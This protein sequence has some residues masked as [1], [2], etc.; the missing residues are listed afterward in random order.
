MSISIDTTTR[1]EVYR[2][3]VRRRWRWRLLSTANG[4]ILA[5]SGQGYSRR[6]DAIAGLA[7]ATG[8][9]HV[10]G[11]SRLG[12]LAGVAYGGRPRRVDLQEV[13]R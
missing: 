3:K 9:R 11:A 1:A 4:N 6:V 8:T 5:D 12:H 10:A 2:S 13:A 7:A